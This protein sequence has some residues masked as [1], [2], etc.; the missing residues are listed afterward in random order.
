MKKSEGTKDDPP[1]AY[2]KNTI[3]SIIAA[4]KIEERKARNKILQYHNI[5]AT[6]RQ[7]NQKNSFA[8]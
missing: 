4:N 8:I 7:T 2:D 3:K 5:M 1:C 6:K